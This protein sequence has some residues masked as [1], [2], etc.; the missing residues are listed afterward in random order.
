MIINQSNL[1]I[2]YTGFK[3]SFQAGLTMVEPTWNR[4]ATEVPSTT[5]TEKYGWL[6]QM[7][8]IRE[9]I[10]DRVI[11]NIE[12]HD[13]SI[14]NK[15]FEITVGVDRNKIED[16][17]YSMFAPIFQEMGRSSKA[18]PDEL[19]YGILNQ[20]FTVPCYDKQPMFSAS[21]PVINSK[22]KEVAVSNYQ[23]GNLQPWFLLSTKRAIKPLIFQN[24]KKFDFIAKTDPKTSDEVFNTKTFIY[25]GD[26]RSNVG[27]GFWQMAFA[28]KAALTAANLQAAY[29]AMQ[30]LTGD[31]G[32]PLGIQPDL[33]VVGPANVFPARQIIKAATL[34]GGGTN[35]NFDLVDILETPWIGI[36]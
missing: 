10:G 11:Q 22:G 8:R 12:A 23:D 25:G 18:H 33:L 36:V 4:I 26:S 14:T 21:H 2:L 32:R 30:T 27:F 19:V 20:G 5:E 7:P 3:A 16:D 9:W 6:G 24:R 17:R 13:Y 34:A 35:T 29:T 1:S 31:N 28:S 15:D